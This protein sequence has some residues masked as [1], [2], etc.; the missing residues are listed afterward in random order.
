MSH[1]ADVHAQARFAAEKMTK[2]NLFTTDRLFCD[3]Y[4][5]EPG[6]EQ[7]AHSHAGSDKVYYVLSGTAVVRIGDEA[8][9]RRRYRRPRPVRGPAC[10]PQPGP[11]RLMVLVLMAPKPS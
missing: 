10:G 5:F 2:N 8:R 11:D 4:C 1:F 3:V 6:Q 9:G 7:K